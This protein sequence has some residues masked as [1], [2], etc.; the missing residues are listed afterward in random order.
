[1]DRTVGELVMADFVN[2]LDGNDSSL[3]FTKGIFVTSKTATSVTIEVDKYVTGGE[4]TVSVQ[5]LTANGGPDG[6]AEVYTKTSRPIVISSLIAGQTYD[7]SVQLRN[8]SNYG[9]TLVLKAI[10]LNEVSF[11]GTTVSAAKSPVEIKQAKSYLELTYA[12]TNQKQFAVAYKS[13]DAIKPYEGNE[14]TDPN[15]PSWLRQY[16]RTYPDAWY[17]F[18]TSL[19]LDASS[20]NS[21]QCGGMGFFINDDGTQGYYV[22]IETVPSLASSDR[23]TL[24]VV[25]ATPSGMKVLFDSQSITGNAYARLY[26]A[27]KYDID[28]KVKISGSTV[29]IEAYVNGFRIYATD[30]D[31]TET[32]DYIFRPTQKIA[33]ASMRGTILF[34]YVYGSSISE[35]KYNATDYDSN[36][37]K[38]QFSNDVLETAYGNL[39]YNASNAQDEINSDYKG[40]TAIE[41]FGSVVREIY[42]VQQKLSTRPAFPISWTVGDNKNVSI[43]GSTASSFKAEAFVLNNSS[44]TVPLVDGALA[45]FGLYG[46]HLG[47]SGQLEY[48][49]DES[50]EYANKEP[51]LFQVNWLQN[52][53]DVKSMAEWIK[54]KVVNRGK[55][56]TM[57]VFGN[58]LITVGDIVSITYPIQGLAVNNTQKFIVTSVSHSYSDGIETE[59]KCRTL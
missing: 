44:T 36:L 26:S 9:N 5:K 58:P 48:S 29:T 49:T 32:L 55:I 39:I 42:H 22:L 46:N 31:N 7:F 33:L 6:S 14:S 54:T 13:F 12:G 1:M 28:V 59:I 35:A 3:N 57:G 2:L 11:N 51:V 56:V 21:N 30:Q 38:G 41:E 53:Q 24:R 4:Y 17:R 15:L 18:G 47:E 52:Q 43:L 40:K 20:G 16:Y 19:F 8:G 45:Q 27:A 34:D 25:K 10:K 37:Y 50:G 23:K